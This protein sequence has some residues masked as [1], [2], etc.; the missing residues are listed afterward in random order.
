MRAGGGGLWWQGCGAA[1]LIPAVDQGGVVDGCGLGVDGDAELEADAF[2]F[3]EGGGGH[4][5]EWSFEG[6]DAAVFGDEEAAGNA[7]GAFFEG[8]QGWTVADVA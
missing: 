1:A 3:V 2:G 8:F 7:A 5:V 6:S 4:A